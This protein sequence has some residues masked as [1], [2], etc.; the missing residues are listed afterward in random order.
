MKT[1]LLDLEIYSFY[2][3]HSRKQKNIKKK[4][5]GRRRRRTHGDRKSKTAIL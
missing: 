2:T 5:Q 4:R 3:L 1:M